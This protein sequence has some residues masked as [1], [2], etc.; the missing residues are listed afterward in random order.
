MDWSTVFSLIDPKLFIVLAACWVLGI[1]IKR[2]PRIP[3]WTIIFVI[4]IFAILMTC[5]LLGWSPESLIQGI[6]V[7]A[8]SVYGNEALKQ[9]KKGTTQS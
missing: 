9:A 4:T 1:A 3:D 7:G 2:I 8:F 6:L 5:W